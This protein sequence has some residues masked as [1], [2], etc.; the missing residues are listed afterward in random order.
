MIFRDTQNNKRFS[1]RKDTKGC[2]GTYKIIV[3]QTL[4]SSPPSFYQIN[5]GEESKILKKKETGIR[6]IILW[7]FLQI[8]GRQ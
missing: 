2:E 4:E 8:S 6:Q 5:L 7:F 1:G 3:K